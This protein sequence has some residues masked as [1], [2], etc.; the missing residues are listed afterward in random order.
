M[1]LLTVV[2]PFWPASR[3]VVGIL[4]LCTC[5]LGQTPS[6]RSEPE[7][8]DTL[9][10]QLKDTRLIVRVRAIRALG[11]TKEPRAVERLVGALKD[12][13]KLVRAGAAEALGAIWGCPPG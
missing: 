7:N 2:R 3:F 11:A 10:G 4:L 8:V 13:D 1:I 6:T 5:F 9:I 12:P